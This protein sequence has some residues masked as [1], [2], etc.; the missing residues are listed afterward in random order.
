MPYGDFKYPEAEPCLKPLDI[1][2]ILIHLINI[3][4]APT[5]Y[6]GKQ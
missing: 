4:L 3:Y 1:L 5:I 2:N 6:L